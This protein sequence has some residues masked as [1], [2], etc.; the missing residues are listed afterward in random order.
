MGADGKLKD[1]GYFVPL[2]GSTSA[3]HWSPDGKVVYN[4]DYGRGIDVLRYTGEYYVPGEPERPGAVKGTEGGG[5]PPA[6]E[7]VACV[8]SAGFKSVRVRPGGG[9]GRGSARVAA[10]G[11]GLDFVVS[12]RVTRPFHVDVFQESAGPRMV[13]RHVASLRNKTGSFSWNGR[14]NTGRRVTDGHYIVRLVMRLPGGRSDIRRIA[15]QRRGGRFLNRPAS[16]MNDRCGILGFF[17]LRRS[18]FGGRRN[19][20]LGI[21]YRVPHGADSVS[22]VALRGARVIKRFNAG[23]QRERT[24]KF[25]LPAKGLPRGTDV[26]VR[27][28]VRRINAKVVSTL[29]ARRV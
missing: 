6:R 16:Y 19:R 9:G 15:V 7:P 1:Q 24:Y 11:A 29:T 12:R 4:I 10:R 23:K 3:P 22:V 20:P 26:R 2:G 13:N 18:A 17:K 28:T 25:E 27:V 21:A 14:G 5:P 8:S